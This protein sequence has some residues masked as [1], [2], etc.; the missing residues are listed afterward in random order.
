MPT[1]H[2]KALT[3]QG[4]RIEDDIEAPDRLAAAA[5]IEQ[6]G[7]VPVSVTESDAGA[8][9]RRT[10]KFSLRSP[11]R[12]PRLRPREVLSFTTE[13]ADLLAAGMDLA[14]ALNCLAGRDQEQ[15]SERIASEL[16]DQIV[17]G[18]SLSEAMATLPTSFPNLYVNMVRAGE[19]SGAM[20]EVLRGLTRHYERFQDLKERVTMALVYPA[21]VILM[22]IATLIFS[23]VYVVPQFKE[24][25]DRMGA[26]LPLPTQILI[27]TSAWL[28]RYGVFLLLGVIL[29][30]ILF[31]RALDTPRGRLWWDGIM[32]RTPL[33]RGI[34]ASGA[35]ATLART[36]QTLLSN[37]VPVL[38]ALRITGETVNNR[39]IGAELERARERVTDGTTISAPLAAGRVFPDSMI[40]MLD[41]G[42]R[43]GDMAGA[44]GHI[45]RRFENELDRNIKVFTTALEPILI[46]VVAI[47][48]GFVA[49]SI[50][51]A[52]FRITSGLEVG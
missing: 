4:A 22:G 38:Q 52:V 9:Q 39:V 3:R 41:I 32:L 48:T 50:L 13:L 35:F 20:D 25:F 37:G 19:A 34:V 10:R 7:H 6:L 42:E 46:V 43:T 15:D 36:L 44:L 2:Y 1:F 30:G 14:T 27:N 11:V 45:G 29:G 16:R 26:A 51:M 24:I 5:R 12:P 21:I 23:L 28:Q 31:K 33:I 17:R 8:P 40:N 49:I 18:K 47:L